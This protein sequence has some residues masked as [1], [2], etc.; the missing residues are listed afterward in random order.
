MED[1]L[2]HY[3]SLDT[4]KLILK[5]K[6]FRLSSLSLMD[7]LE[8]GG[9][10][11]LNDFGKFIY[12]SS[13]TDNPID[14]VEFWG[15]SGKDNGVRI[16]MKKNPFKTEIIKGE[17]KEDVEI[18]TGLKKY[19]NFEQVPE[20][21]FFPGVTELIEMTYTNNEKLLKPQVIARSE[22]GGFTIRNE[23]LGI[24]KRKQWSNQ[25]EWRYRLRSLPGEPLIRYTNG[26]ID[27]EEFFKE[28]I[29]FKRMDY[30][31]L[32]LKEDAFDDVEI[33]I[34]PF[35]DDEG[36]KEIEELVKSYIPNAILKESKMQIR[37]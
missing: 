22:S 20:F 19:F 32:P 27:R 11:D 36:K 23:Y 17:D 6:T 26:V 2:Y 30:I 4:L 34:S 15:Y 25:C 7:D 21:L 24:F 33:L 37:R 12:I 18:N 35:T 1:Y 8:E 14:T 9:T 5:N 10:S 31:D 16:R 3:T 29:N 13:W 28:L